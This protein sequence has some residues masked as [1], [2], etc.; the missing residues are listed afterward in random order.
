MIRGQCAVRSSQRLAA[1]RVQRVAEEDEG[2]QRQFGGRQRRNPASERLAPDDRWWLARRL[3]RG[4]VDGDRSLRGPAGQLHQPYV[5]A[6]CAEAALVRTQL[7]GVAGR[8]GCQEDAPRHRQRIAGAIVRTRSTSRSVGLGMTT[9]KITKSDAEW[10]SELTPEQYRVLRQKGTEHAFSGACGMSTA[11]GYTDVPDAGPSCSTHPRSSTQGR[12]GPRSTSR[13]TPTPSRPSPIESFF[14]T[15]TEV[16]CARCG[17]HL[18]HIFDDARASRPAC[19]T[20]STRR[21]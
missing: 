2:R 19:A 12:A 13:L 3:D 16:H 20:A 14:M 18:G 6:A 10:R 1:G 11:P 9:E 21:R 4:G 8:A 17:G 5:E 7:L 15:R